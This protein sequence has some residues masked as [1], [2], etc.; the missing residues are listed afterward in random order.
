M[1]KHL[2]DF[3]SEVQTLRCLEADVTDGTVAQEAAN[4]Q[5]PAG[6]TVLG[7]SHEG[8]QS[9]GLAATQR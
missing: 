6:V 4:T 2:G 7:E 9:G 1:V 8:L 3:H 5:T